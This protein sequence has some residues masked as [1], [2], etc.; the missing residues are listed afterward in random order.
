MIQEAIQTQPSP[1]DAFHQTG[2]LFHWAGAA[3][4]TAAFAAAALL[5]LLT[6][7]MV[8]AP[9]IT[10][11]CTA[12]LRERNFLSFLAGA[13]LLAVFL[14]VGHVGQKFPPI[15][16]AAASGFTVLLL[17]GLSAAAED[18]G[19]RLA[20]VSG[21][22]GTRASHLVRGWLIFAAS[23]CVPVIGW[24]IVLPYVALSGLGSVLVATFSRGEPAPAPREPEFK[25]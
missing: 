22:E 21:R 1:A 12:A 7:T 13:L 15:G 11:R 14:V 5:G 17:L 8:V 9:G 24:F 16:L 3:T 6:M 19:R 25:G 23:A 4:I 20:W 10:S 2:A 18:L